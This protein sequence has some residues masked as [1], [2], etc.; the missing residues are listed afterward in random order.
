MAVERNREIVPRTGYAEAV[1][2]DGDRIEIVSLIGG[3]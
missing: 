3:G 2:N 1:L